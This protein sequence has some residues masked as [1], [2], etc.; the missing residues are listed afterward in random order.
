MHARAHS[1]DPLERRGEEAVPCPSCG[2]PEIAVSECGNAAG[3]LFFFTPRTLKSTH[4]GTSE[5]GFGCVQRAENSSFCAGLIAQR[6][7]GAHSSYWF[8]G[9]SPLFIKLKALPLGPESGSHCDA[10]E[11]VHG[12]VSGV[13]RKNEGLFFF[14]PFVFLTE[15]G[16]AASHCQSHLY[17]CSLTLLSSSAPLLSVS[18]PLPF[19]PSVQLVCGQRQQAWS[20]NGERGH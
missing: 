9:P 15:F 12:S 2:L 6:R 18:L 8:Y 3:S 14:W 4:W 1:V 17:T 5:R 10:N 13:N 16:T 19:T 7:C 11:Y 20:I